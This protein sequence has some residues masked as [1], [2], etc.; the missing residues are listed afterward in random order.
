MAGDKRALYMRDNP[1]KRDFIEL[2]E[3]V[4]VLRF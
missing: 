2:L 1:D 4:G 3:S